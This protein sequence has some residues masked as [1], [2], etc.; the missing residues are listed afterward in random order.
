[1]GLLSFFGSKKKEDTQSASSKTA[2]PVPHKSVTPESNWEPATVKWFNA[3][4]GFGFLERGGK[5]PDIFVHQSTLNRCRIDELV[6]GQ[7]VEVKWGKSLKKA[8]GLE[9]AELRLPK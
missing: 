4:K 6:E 8:G 2:S 7:N 1:M 3:K 9:A 5:T